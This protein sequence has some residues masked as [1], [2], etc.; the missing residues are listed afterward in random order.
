MNDVKIDA[1]YLVDH[2]MT[3]FFNGK[4]RVPYEQLLTFFGEFN[5]YF[6]QDDVEGFLREVQYIKR[7]SDEIEFS[8][9]ASMIRNIIPN[10]I[11][12]SIKNMN[13][14]SI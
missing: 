7:G 12:H 4:E 11:A 9:L 8:E 13:L 3:M 2:L 5:S 10:E 6:E 1:Y 14:I